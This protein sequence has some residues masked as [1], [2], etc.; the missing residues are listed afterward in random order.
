MLLRDFRHALRGLRRGPATVALAIL[1]L[2]LGLGGNTAAYTWIDALLLRP[3]PFEDLGG[4]Y[5]VW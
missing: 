4:L 3:Y 2:G 1:T 5:A